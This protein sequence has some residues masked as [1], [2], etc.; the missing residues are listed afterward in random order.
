MI[1]V[2]KEKLPKY[3]ETQLWENCQFHINITDISECS[4][5][6]LG[7]KFLKN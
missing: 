7:L 1:A 4:N 6:E 3:R 2:Q 5:L